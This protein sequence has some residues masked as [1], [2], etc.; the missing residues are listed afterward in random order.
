MWRASQPLQLLHADICGLISPIS[1]SHKRNFFTFINDFSRKLWV[2]F[3]TEKSDA[4]NG[5]NFSKQRFRKKISTSIRGLRTDRDGEFTSNE[6]FEF[7]A[8]NGI[9]RQLT[10]AYTPQ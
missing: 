1:N 3:L 7:Y 2:F 5:F 8:T 10:A 4:L 6:F 9:H